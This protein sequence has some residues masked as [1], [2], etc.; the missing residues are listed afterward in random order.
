MELT[1]LSQQSISDFSKEQHNHDDY[2]EV[3]DMFVAILSRQTSDAWQTHNRRF[4]NDLLFSSWHDW[5]MAWQFY[6]DL[7][8]IISSH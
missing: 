5:Y 6:V 8:L 4:K 1:L 7:V 2:N 3:A